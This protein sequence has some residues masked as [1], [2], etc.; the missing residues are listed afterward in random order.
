MRARALRSAVS[1]I[2]TSRPL[3][4]GARDARVIPRAHARRRRRLGASAAQSPAPNMGLVCVRVR[5]VALVLVWRWRCVRV[6]LRA[7]RGRAGAQVRA[8][9]RA[10]LCGVAGRGLRATVVWCC[11]RGA[12]TILALAIAI[13]LALS[14]LYIV[15]TYYHTIFNIHRCIHNVYPADLNFYFNFYFF[16]F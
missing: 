4:R 8:C 13:A 5:D 9:Q 6:R 2:D 10:A 11:G 12:A 7:A 16:N 1:A 15:Y 3:T 14:I